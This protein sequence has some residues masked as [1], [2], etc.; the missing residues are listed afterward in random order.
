MKRRN[1]NFDINA[2]MPPTKHVLGVLRKIYKKGYRN[3][4]SV[5]SEGIEASNM[6]QTARKQVAEALHCKDNEIFFTSGASESNSWVYANY[7]NC[8][9]ISPKSH[10]SLLINKQFNLLGINAF[11]YVVSETGEVLGAK[12]MYEDDVYFVDLTQAIGHIDI[13]LNDNPNIIFASASGHKFGGILGCGILYIKEEYQDSFKPLIYGSQENGLRGG[14]ENLPAIVCFG[15]AIK[16][17]TKN[18]DKNNKKIFDI[19]NYIFHNID[20]RVKVGGHLNVINITFNNILAA[21]AVQLF[22]HYGINISAGSAC[23]SGE[24]KPSQVY[25]ESGYSEKEALR[26]IRVSVGCNNTLREAKKFIKV[27]NKILDNYDV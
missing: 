24:E 20:K 21:T 23:S 8:L 22:D 12:T 15:E 18:I 19:T 1:I 4:S 3:P 13:N 16:E 10:H 6:I 5:Y 9:E 11:P 17:A 27:L 7:S 25:L 14:T 26:T 2:T